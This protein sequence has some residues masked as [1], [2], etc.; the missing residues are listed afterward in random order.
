M[1]SADFREKAREKMAGKWGKAAIITF[2]YLLAFF[3]IGFI[4]GL[5][6]ESMEWLF[7][8][9]VFVIEIPLS[10]GYILSLFKLYNAE[11][12]NGFDFL[13]LGFN[14]FSKSWSVF[15][16]M[17]LKL[18]VPIILII[19]SVVV[20][21]FGIGATIGSSLIALTTYNSSATSIAS[22]AIG[23]FVIV[24]IVGMILYIV[25]IIFM[26]TKSLYYALSYIVLANH[27]EMTGKQAV[28]ESRKLM[29]GNRSKLFVLQLS[30]IGWAILA[31]LSLGIGLFWLIPYVQ[32]SLFAFYKKLEGKDDNVEVISENSN[33]AE[34]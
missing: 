11:D 18:L 8:I 9:L 19:I 13:K 23:G 29:E 1:R 10:F 15:F 2:C 6:P 30:F 16:N 4:S 21:S 34:E 3:L 12:V 24:M 26:I 31:A 20:M 25:S 5:L 7:S 33:K 28:E 22:G 14:N 32:F 27:P 17:L